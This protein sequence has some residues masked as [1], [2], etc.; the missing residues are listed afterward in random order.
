MVSET[1][2]LILLIAI[3]IVFII[4]LSGFGMDFRKWLW[5]VLLKP[6]GTVEDIPGKPFFCSLCMTWWIGLI[7]LLIIKQ[8]TLLN[9]AIV[10]MVAYLTPIIASTIRLIYDILAKIINLLY[11]WLKL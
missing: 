1:V 2:W 4:D 9:I 11:D 6:R 5:K 8:F 10:A 3:L 7:T